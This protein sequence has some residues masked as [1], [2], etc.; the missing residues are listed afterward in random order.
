VTAAQAGESIRDNV[1]FVIAVCDFPQY[2]AGAR[3]WDDHHIGNV[4]A[5]L[6]FYLS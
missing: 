1:E 6:G 4:N 5:G 2:T 3:L